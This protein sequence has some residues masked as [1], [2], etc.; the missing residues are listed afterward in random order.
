MADVSNTRVGLIGYG[1]VGR[2]F[3]RALVERGVAEVAAYD[4]LL[5]DDARSSDMRKDAASAGVRL[6]SST[7]DLLDRAN[8]V[9]SAVTASESLNAARD[10][11][12]SIRPGTYFLDINS[13]SPG[14]KTESSA[15]IEG[16]GAHYVE[17]A[18]M[19][20]VPP[21]GIRA[22]MLLGGKRAAAVAPLLTGVGFNVKPVSQM[23]GVASAIKMCR[24]VIIKGMEAIVIESF[25][26]ARRFGIE[27]YVLESLAETFPEIDWQRV[28][29]YFFSRVAQHGR[30]R[31]E[32]MREA[33]TT[34]REAGLEPFMAAATADRQ[35]WVAALAAEG[36]FAEVAKAPSWQ[37]YADAILGHLERRDRSANTE[38]PKRVNAPL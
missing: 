4:I 24:S 13:A 6:V 30:R 25:L 17:S 34:V 10:A 37:D 22:P 26:S 27:E 5:H 11:A 12:A 38:H 16:A 31:A 3:G 28:G 32:E 35:G 2:I 9:I 33:A 8:L 19:T 14:A 36:V 15:L 20:S 1:E 18:V 23:L 7:P 21:Y 29:G